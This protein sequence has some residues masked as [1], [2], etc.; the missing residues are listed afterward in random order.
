[1]GRH[2]RDIVT[3]E[4]MDPE[5]LSTKQSPVDSDAAN[6]QQLAMKAYLE[7]IQREDL[8]RDPASRLMQ[9]DDPFD[10]GDTVYYWRNDPSKIKAGKQMGTEAVWSDSDG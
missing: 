3:V 7:A 6:V 9:T 4:Y 8:R 1:M 2:P 10:I 5:N